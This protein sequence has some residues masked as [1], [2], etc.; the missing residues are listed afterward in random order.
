LYGEFPKSSVSNLANEHA[1]W[2][3]FESTVHETVRR[4][5]P[6]NPGCLPQDRKAWLRDVGRRYVT[7]PFRWARFLR[8]LLARELCNS[9][10]ERS[11]L[12]W[13]SRTYVCPVEE[14]IWASKG[15]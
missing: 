6:I 8:T 3:W 1:G 4:S 13:E 10:L 11:E 14:E 5:V 7:L 12:R 9:P 2:T 15:A